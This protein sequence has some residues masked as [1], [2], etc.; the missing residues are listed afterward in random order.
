[1]ILYLPVLHGSKMFKSHRG[2]FIQASKFFFI[3][4]GHAE[5]DNERSLVQNEDL[6]LIPL[7]DCNAGSNREDNSSTFSMD[8]AELCGNGPQSIINASSSSEISSTSTAPRRY[9]SKRKIV[10]PSM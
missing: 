7:P 9:R 6:D 1:M 8:W 4:T 10:D 3:L 2:S 5:Q